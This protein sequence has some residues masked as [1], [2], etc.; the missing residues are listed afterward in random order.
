MYY[1]KSKAEPVEEVLT[2][3][4]SC[5]RESCMGWIREEFSFEKNPQCPF[6]QSEMEYTTRKLPLLKN[7]FKG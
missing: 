5:I 7:H 1:A 4:W 6:C 3:V 2:A